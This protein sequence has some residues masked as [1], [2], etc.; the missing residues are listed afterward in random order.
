M[1][2]RGVTWAQIV[3]ACTRPHVIEP[4]Q[5]R[6]RFTRGDLVVV[7]ADDSTVV[8]VLLREQD[9]WNDAGFRERK[10]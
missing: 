7:V 2:A 5:G 4:H 1:N 10:S 6:R 3:E 9:T 8:T